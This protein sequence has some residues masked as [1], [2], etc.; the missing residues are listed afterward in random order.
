MTRNSAKSVAA[1]EETEKTTRPGDSV[2]EGQSVLRS[3]YSPGVNLVD[4]AIDN[5][6]REILGR[7]VEL[8]PLLRADQAETER[9]GTYSVEMHEKFTEAGLYR[10]L[11]PRRFGGLELG[12]AAFFRVIAEVARGCP[13]TGWCLCLAAGHALQVSS[14]F[15]ERAQKEVFERTGQMVSPA[16]GN[17]GDAQVIPV[18]DGFRI[19]GTWRYCSG[20]PHSTHFMGLTGFPAAE[21][22]GPAVD[23]WFIASRDQ[24]EVLNDWGGILGM[25]GS[26][27]NSIRLDDVFVPNYM[28]SESSWSSETDGP[29]I[30]SLLHNNPVYGGTFEGFAEGEI[31]AIAAGT[32][33]AAVDEYVKTI[34]T[35][36]VP[37]SLGRTLR[38][39]DTNFQRWLGTALAWADAA[40]AI[41]V[42]GGQ[43]Y[44]E[45][46]R[47]SVEG[48]EP[49]SRDKSLRLN[50]MYFAAEGLAFDAVQHLLRN[51]STSSILD[52]QPMQRY[53]RDMSTVMSRVDA[54]ERAAAGAALEYLASLKTEQVSQP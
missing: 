35:T 16:S 2:T 20:S 38:A 8:R 27:S 29:T 49:F 48:I 18:E 7:V 36:F 46:A 26:G 31:A 9:R 1:R 30:G 40:A 50:D 11:Q 24:Y 19:S 14:Y 43:L 51:G 5:Q 4:P 47:M 32:A 28:V 17:S 15:S 53:Y 13:S 22:D 21:P 52:G 23:A 44:E 25:K 34:S 37:N 12:V 10:I 33:M 41:S 3:S 42:R 54:L 45:Y 6:V 39:Q